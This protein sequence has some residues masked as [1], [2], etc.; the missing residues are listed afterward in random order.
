M[1]DISEQSRYL[2]VQKLSLSLGLFSRY[3]AFDLRLPG[4]AI[5]ICVFITHTTSF[6]WIGAV[7]TFESFL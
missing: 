4:F 2:L 3:R 1:A 7:V 6:N 5:S